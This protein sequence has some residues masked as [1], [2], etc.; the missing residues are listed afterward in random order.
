MNYLLQEKMQQIKQMTEEQLEVQG[1]FYNFDELIENEIV[2][3]F[4]KYSQ[5]M[6]SNFKK[7]V[8]LIEMLVNYFNET[9][10]EIKSYHESISTETKSNLSA[11]ITNE[12]KALAQQIQAKITEWA[13]LKREI[14]Q[15]KQHSKA[16]ETQLGLV[17]LK[18]I[19]NAVPLTTKEKVLKIMKGER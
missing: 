9:L 5:R 4:P 12:K 11:Q 1:V 15:I 3:D 14:E 6:R 13:N 7:G 2:S 8:D 10:D 17:T 19:K 16:T 18:D